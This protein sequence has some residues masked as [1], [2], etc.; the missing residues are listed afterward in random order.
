L[1]LVA[2]V[3]LFAQH[4]PSDARVDSLIHGRV[5]EGRA[6]GIVLGLLESDGSRR[7]FAYGD[8]GPGARPLGPKSVFE[9]G[10]ITKVFTGILLAEMSLRGEVSLD[11]PVQE[12]LPD[13]VTMPARPGQVITLEHLATHRSSLPRLPSNMS[14]ADPANPYADYTS[15]QL[16][17]FLSSYALTRDVGER[18]EY[19]NLAVGLLGWVLALRAG[20]DYETLVRERILK[21]LGMSM[22]G[23]T[24]DPEMS[25]WLVKGHDESGNVVSNWDIPTVHCGPMSRTCSRFWRRMSASRTESWRRPCN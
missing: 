23:I 16:Y 19:S 18:Y 20:A 6:T 11:D 5:D 7:I 8:A 22:S 14:P 13:G 2:A 21:P 9:I 4:F 10:S 25:A 24:L 3:P 17:D 12:Y 15:Q 1:L